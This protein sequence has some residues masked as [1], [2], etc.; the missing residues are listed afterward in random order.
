M[1][2]ATRQARFAA[3]LVDYICR[4]TEEETENNDEN[5]EMME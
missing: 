1:F 4:K 2:S 5:N 3:A